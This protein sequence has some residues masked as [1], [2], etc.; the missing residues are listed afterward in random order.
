VAGQIGKIRHAALWAIGLV[1]SATSLT[2]FAESY[3]ALV[4]W[5]LGHGLRGLWAFIFPAQIDTFVLV[6]ELALFVALADSWP[7]RS[8]LAAWA[9]TLA[10]LAVSVAG[11]VGHVVGHQVADRATAAVPPVAA[12]SALAVGLGVLKRVVQTRHM[13]PASQACTALA[14]V[15]A[16]AESAAR[17]ALAASMAASNP[18]SVRQLADRFGISRSRAVKVRQQV[19]AEANGHLPPASL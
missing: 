10:G 8:R 19:D 5:A 2:A 15:P 16:D 7:A 14:V 4:L 18:L 1:V 3:R 11:N 13:A 17:M 6:G 12:A 9:V